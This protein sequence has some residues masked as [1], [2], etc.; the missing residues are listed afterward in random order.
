MDKAW[1]L[2]DNY[3]RAHGTVHS[4]GTI[5]FCAV[6]SLALDI[7]MIAGGLVSIVDTYV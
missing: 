2:D 6:P 4:G 1:E 7:L 3:W 5:T